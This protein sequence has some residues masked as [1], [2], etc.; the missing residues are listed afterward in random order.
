MCNEIFNPVSITD[1]YV[2]NI[3]IFLN[4]IVIKVNILFSYSMGNLVHWVYKNVPD[5]GD[6]EVVKIE[7]YIII[8]NI[9]ISNC[10]IILF[11]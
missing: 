1:F 4:L 11:F 2:I 5:N 7:L 3:N 8:I 9:L 10:T 6:L